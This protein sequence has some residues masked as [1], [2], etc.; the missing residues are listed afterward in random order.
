M[1]LAV[2]RGCFLLVSAFFVLWRVKKNHLTKVIYSPM[3]NIMKFKHLLICAVVLSLVA[4]GTSCKFS[5]E[6]KFIGKWQVV[7]I[8]ERD[9]ESQLWETDEN[10]EDGQLV[11]KLLNDGTSFVYSYG[12]PDKGDNWSYNKSSHTISYEGDEYTVDKITFKEMIWVLREDCGFGE[13]EE[14]RI[15]FKRVK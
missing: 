15:V 11:L 4:F 10:Y 8:Q 12:I 3:I 9:S 5:P 1:H 7:K 6:K 13:W 14:E 2:F